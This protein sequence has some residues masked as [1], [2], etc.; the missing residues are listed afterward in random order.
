MPRVKYDKRISPLRLQLS[1]QLLLRRLQAHHMAVGLP[2]TM[3]DTAKD[4]L[5]AALNVPDIA[6]PALHAAQI[7]AF[8]RFQAQAH[9]RLA[10]ELQKMK[11]ELLES[12][13]MR[14]S[15]NDEELAFVEAQE[16]MVESSRSG[17]ESVPVVSSQ[18]V[19]PL[20][21]LVTPTAEDL[22]TLDVAPDADSGFDADLPEPGQN[23]G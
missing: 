3:Q 5:L 18:E 23:E 2:G 8:N 19:E 21:M 11:I 4:L 14:L 16:A 1:D 6:E 20:A 10:S 7:R 9:Y 12:Q 17:S 13:R 22:A 15:L